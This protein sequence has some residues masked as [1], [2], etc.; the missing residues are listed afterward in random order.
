MIQFEEVPEVT[1]DDFQLDDPFL[2][3][4]RVPGLNFSPLDTS[5]QPEGAEMS[6]ITPWQRKNLVTG[7][8]NRG[9]WINATE[10]PRNK[11]SRDDRGE[12]DSPLVRLYLLGCR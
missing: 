4:L 2:E 12:F 8:W 7:V 3:A 5:F 10:I 6:V 11:A 9:S 1:S